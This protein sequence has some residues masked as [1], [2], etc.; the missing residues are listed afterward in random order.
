MPKDYFTIPIPSLLEIAEKR[1]IAEHHSLPRRERK[2]KT[3]D[4][5]RAI[6]VLENARQSILARK[7]ATQQPPA[8]RH[9]TTALSIINPTTLE[10]RPTVEFEIPYWKRPVPR[11]KPVNKIIDT[12]FDG[13]EAQSFDVELSE[14]RHKVD[15]T[16]K[17]TELAATAS[18][19]TLFEV[20]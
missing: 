10:P 19:A 4:F 18:A 12:S 7:W 5:K 14:W 15:V 20:Q 6:G 17:Q 13:V 3:R 1:V 9:Q 2:R 8:A 11:Q 16:S